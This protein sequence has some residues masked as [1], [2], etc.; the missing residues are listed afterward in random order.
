[1]KTRHFRDDYANPSGA[2]QDPVQGVVYVASP[3][4][5]TE[6]GRGHRS[7]PIHNGIFPDK[8][9]TVAA[10]D[11]L[12]HHAAIFEMNVESYPRRAAYTAATPLGDIDDVSQRDT[13]K[14]DD[15]EK[16]TPASDIET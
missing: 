8:A 9:M 14:P 7:K 15:K 16:A 13:E 11:R 10:I 3:K 4:A 5:S 12:V 1:M 6:T 2:D